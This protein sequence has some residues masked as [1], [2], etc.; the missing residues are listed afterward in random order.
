[1]NAMVACL[2]SLFACTLIIATYS[3]IL[4]VLQGFNR[5][6]LVHAIA[7]RHFLDPRVVEG[8]EG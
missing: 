2:S 1:M 5:H 3:E 4:Q 8:I 6:V 7:R